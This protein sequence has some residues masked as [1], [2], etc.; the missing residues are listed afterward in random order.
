MLRPGASATP[1]ATGTIPVLPVTP[2]ML[3]AL[4]GAIAGGVK[5]IWYADRRVEFMSLDDML[6]AY[7]W[8][9]AQLGI[10]GARPVRRGACFAK[11]LDGSTLNAGPEHAEIDDVLFERPIPF[12]LS[13]VED[14]AWNRAK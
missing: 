8:L 4:A 11:G 10:G 1:Y 14:V 5:V 6:R 2:E 13:R 9:L 12:D 7:D 3:A